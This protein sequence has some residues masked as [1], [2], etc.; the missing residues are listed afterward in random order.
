MA[1]RKLKNGITLFLCIIFVLFMII[2]PFYLLFH[3][4]NEMNYNKVKDKPEWTGVITFWDYPRLDQS[5]GTNFRWIYDKIRAFE[6]AYPGVYIQFKPLTWERG[7]IQV[8]SAAKLGQL[9][10]IIPI[11]SDYSLLHKGLLEPLDPFLSVTEIQDFRENALEAVTYDG[12]IWAMPW[13]MTTYTMALNLDIFQD[14][15][16]EPPMDGLWHYDEFIEKMKV[17]TFASEEDGKID[18]YGL[19]GF[20]QPG[21]YNLW[22]ILLSDGGEIVDEGLH[23][24]FN[25]HRAQKGIE[26]LINLKNEYAVMPEDFGENNANDAWTHF[27]Q[28]Q[29]TAVYPTG[30]WSLN[31][32]KQMK[33]EGTGFNY[34]IAHFPI[35]EKGAPITMSNMV[36]SYGMTKQQDPL[37]LEMGVTFLKFLSE[38]KHQQE[39]TRLGVFPV[40]KSVGNIYEADPLMTM[41]YET[42]TYTEIPPP[43]PYWKEIDEIIQNE[44]RQGVLEKKTPQ[45][46][47]QDAEE[48]VNVLIKSK[49]Q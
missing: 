37:K 4:P 42:L 18:H 7:P 31:V 17:L 2:G 32:L 16:V 28:E 13:M 21:Y 43:H 24:V 3:R 49:Q 12:R 41:I 47:L 30:T 36:G 11:G 6:K 22:G 27:Y 26:K 48:K 1:K 10:D 5:T 46:V 14:R 34:S 35:G 15:G 44:I 38:E 19:G 9:P 29:K 39:L 8:E 40:K 25:D 33:Q 23:Y 20:I 45:Q